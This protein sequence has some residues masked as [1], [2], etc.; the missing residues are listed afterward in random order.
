MGI[1]KPGRSAV[2]PIEKW[3]RVVKTPGMGKSGIE[4]GALG[5]GLV[6]GLSLPGTRLITHCGK[7]PFTSG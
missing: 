4:E 1:R 2:L 3:R 6:T 7:Y 5:I